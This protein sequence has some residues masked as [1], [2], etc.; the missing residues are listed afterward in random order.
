MPSSCS[1][2]FARGPASIGGGLLARAVPDDD[3]GAR[4]TDYRAARIGAAVACIAVVFIILVV[5]AFRVDYE[6]SPIIVT[7]VLATA[8]AFLGVELRDSLRG[9]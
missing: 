8:A 1:Q 9:R 7:A 2:P 6:A 5:D 3:P 4:R